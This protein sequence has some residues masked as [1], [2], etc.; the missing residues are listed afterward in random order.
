MGT[1]AIENACPGLGD[2]EAASNGMDFIAM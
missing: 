2:L 1:S